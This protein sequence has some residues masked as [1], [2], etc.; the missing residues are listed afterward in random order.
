MRAVSVAFTLRGTGGFNRVRT[1]YRTKYAYCGVNAVSQNGKYPVSCKQGAFLLCKNA[2]ANKT[3]S[4]I[5][6]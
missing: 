4:P 3:V 5:Q 1:A 2:R 6:W